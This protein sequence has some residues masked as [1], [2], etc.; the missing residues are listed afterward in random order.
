MKQDHVHKYETI[1]RHGI[2][3]ELLELGLEAAELRRCATC[4][5]EMIFVLTKKDKWFPV[6]DERSVPDPDIL[7]A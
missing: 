7:L 5:K 2:T 3:Y 4:Q 6:V 1:S